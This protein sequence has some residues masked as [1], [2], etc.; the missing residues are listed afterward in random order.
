MNA[1]EWLDHILDT[2]NAMTSGKYE[3]CVTAD[4]GFEIFNQEGVKIAKMTTPYDKYKRASN[5]YGFVCE[6][7][8][9]PRLVEMLR[10]AA[11]IIEA[12]ATINNGGDP[13]SDALQELYNMTEPKQ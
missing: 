4:S 2:H 10:F 8:A 9:V 6:H 3:E 1:Q 7:N 5:A 12:Q 13:V 11:G